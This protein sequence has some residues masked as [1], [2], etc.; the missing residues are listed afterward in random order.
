MIFL[1]F[2][3]SCSNFISLVSVFAPPPICDVGACELDTDLITD[4]DRG[5]ELGRDPSRDPA[6]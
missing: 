5:R 3:T 1:I 6:R 2:L 4:F